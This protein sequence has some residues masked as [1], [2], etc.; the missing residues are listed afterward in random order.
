VARAAG[1]FPIHQEICL[2]TTL[3]VSNLPHS[4]TETT[5]AVKFARFGNV[6]SVRIE[7]SN[8]RRCGRIDMSTAADAQRAINGLNLVDYD[9]MLISVYR[10]VASV[11]AL[12]V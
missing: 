12:G 4:A 9:G 10:A 3:V 1:D 2:S 11:R 6:L 5:L 8:T 7:G